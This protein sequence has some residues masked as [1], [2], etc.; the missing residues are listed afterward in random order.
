MS[1]A[2]AMKKL[3]IAQAMERSAVSTLISANSL[4]QFQPQQSDP[5]SMAKKR[6]PKSKKSVPTKTKKTKK[7]STKKTKK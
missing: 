2:A 4:K 1:A 5:V 6:K 3:R 7:S